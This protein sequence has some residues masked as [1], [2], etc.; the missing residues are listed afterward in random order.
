MAVYGPD[1]KVEKVLTMSGVNALVPIH[2]DLQ[3][4]IASLQ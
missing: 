2:H 3:S 4:A 1:E